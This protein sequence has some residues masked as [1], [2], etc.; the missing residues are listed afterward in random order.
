MLEHLKS[1]AVSL[2]LEKLKAGCENKDDVQ[3]ERRALPDCSSWTRESCRKLWVA[4]GEADSALSLCADGP[5]TKTSLE[6]EIFVASG[7]V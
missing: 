3:K 1:E 5:G 2:K 7:L 4:L 6:I